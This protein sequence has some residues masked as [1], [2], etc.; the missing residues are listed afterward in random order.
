MK[1][2]AFENIL[3]HGDASPHSSG[4]HD[5]CTVRNTR[6]GCG[7]RIVKRPSAVVSPVMPA[8]DPFGLYG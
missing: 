2:R 4:C 1:R 3:N 6:S 7:I 5:I 8:G